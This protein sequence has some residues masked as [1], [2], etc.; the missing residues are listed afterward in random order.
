MKPALV[1]ASLILAI[2]A[3][4]VPSAAGEWA[5][6]YVEQIAAQNRIE[7]L[8]DGTYY[9]LSGGA[10][11][12]QMGT[13]RKT[14]DKLICI[15]GKDGTKTEF[16]IKGESLI[17]SVE[18]EWVRREAALKYP[19]KDAVPVTFV[20]IDEKTH[21]PITEFSY[22]Y[23]ISTTSTEFDPLLVRPIVVKS[24]SGTFSIPAPKNCRIDVHIDGG[25]VIVVPPW[26]QH[27]A[28][29]PETKERRFEVPVRIGVA[30][31]G[32][33]VDARTKAPVAGARV[34]PTM[35]TP[36]GISPDHDRSVK[37]DA[38]GRFQIRGVDPTLGIE[39]EHADYA[40]NWRH[41][42]DVGQEV[43]QKAYTARI[44][45]QHGDTITG[46]VKDAAGRPLVDVDVSDGAGSTAESRADGSF[47]LR[48]PRAWN[49]QHYYLTFAKVGYLKATLYPAPPVT[50]PLSVVL[51]RPPVLTGKVVGP[52]GR[53]VGPFTVVAGA[54]R[55][56]YPFGCSSQTVAQPG[57]SFS[58]PVHVD[59]DYG[60]EGKVWIAV[61]A[62]HFAMSEVVAD[63]W[64]GTKT[65]TV[66]L[67]S[68][69]SVGG[70]IASMTGTGKNSGELLVELLPVKLQ[71]D[72]PLVQITER[73][74]LGRMHLALAGGG[75]F[76]FDHVSPGAYRLVVSGPAI[77]PLSTELTVGDAD[78]VLGTLPTSGR[79][80]IAGVVFHYKN[81]GP[82]AF[83][84]GKVLFKVSSGRW[85]PDEF[86]DAAPIAFTADEKGEFR[87]DNV[88][89]GEVMVDFEIPS[90][91]DIIDSKTQETRVLEGKTTEVRVNGSGPSVVWLDPSQIPS[92]GASYSAPALLLTVAGCSA[93]MAVGLG[94]ARR[95]KK[96]AR[97]RLLS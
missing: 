46:T 49:F 81:P 18:L 26:Y 83:A 72:N 66:Q 40:K 89:V 79:G 43:V 33:V 37:A 27:F 21:T 31:D 92:P 8:P 47:A 62:P 44:E 9:S 64:Q 39:V 93:G 35:F 34:S 74:Q 90:G 30:I 17:E 88:P 76:R 97:G 96:R 86:G 77:S 12:Y 41:F 2:L 36:P 16:R 23:Q 45:L 13:Y 15:D 94:L 65:I 38:Q 7:F 82:W 28:L 51:E 48:N 29:T 1:F 58:V 50:S 87:L 54:G 95:W 6:V 20:V 68:G 85:G 10:W 78:A 55:D 91:G 56:P 84:K 67:K 19:W 63:G 25:L 53:P 52:D 70:A 80:S 71:K 60:K 42:A 24:P 32:V 4:A 73:Q 59:F 3:H 22:R 57:G 75:G 69:V 11:Q 5:G 14:Q 61:K